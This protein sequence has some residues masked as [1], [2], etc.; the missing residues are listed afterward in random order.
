VINQNAGVRY[1]IMEVKFHTFLT[2]AWPQKA[3]GPQSWSGCQWR[4]ISATGINWI[5][6]V[7]LY[8]DSWALLSL[9]GKLLKISACCFLSCLKVELADCIAAWFKNSVSFLQWIFWTLRLW[10]NVTHWLHLM[11]WA[12]DSCLFSHVISMCF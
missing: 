12:S 6:L 7:S 8:P 9:V 4:E 11:G 2:S 1:G 3:S 5:S 10:S